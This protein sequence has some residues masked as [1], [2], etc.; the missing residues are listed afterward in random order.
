MVFKTQRSVSV[1]NALAKIQLF[2]WE[3]IALDTNRIGLVN[4]VAYELFNN[5]NYTRS[6]SE[7]VLAL[8][9]NNSH[10]S[11]Y[12]QVASNFYSAAIEQPF[13]PLVLFIL[14]ANVNYCFY[15]FPFDGTSILMEKSMNTFDK[16]SRRT[17]PCFFEFVYFYCPTMIDP[18]WSQTFVS[19][20]NLTNNTRWI[21]FRLRDYIGAQRINVFGTQVWWNTS[22]TIGF[23]LY[24]LDINLPFDANPYRQEM[25]QMVKPAW[26]HD[27]FDY[28][29]GYR[30]EAIFQ[31][32]AQL[33]SN[34]TRSRPKLFIDRLNYANN[35]F[36]S[37]LTRQA[38]HSVMLMMGVV[39]LL[40]VT[41]VG[42]ISGL[43]YGLLYKRKKERKLKNTPNI[44]D[45]FKSTGIRDTPKHLTPS[46]H[47]SPNVI[48]TAFQSPLLE[49][50]ANSQPP[51]TPAKLAGP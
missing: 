18:V 30:Q 38:R 27:G 49:P 28:T 15:T 14:E 51:K 39:I 20:D 42:L 17:I 8:K 44:N 11:V 2:E 45:A 34:K 22:T 29:E 26:Q 37:F 21:K 25:I 36:C 7:V 13:G 3:A 35:E 4:R 50:A 48:K 43:F 9:G 40:F 5:G 31:F 24:N 19:N 46:P 12:S 23:D 32:H 16:A 10:C 1:A 33:R 6:K 47:P 41:N